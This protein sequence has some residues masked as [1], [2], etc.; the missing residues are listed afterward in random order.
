MSSL[1]EPNLVLVTQIFI[2][3]L[4]RQRSVQ[5]L[6]RQKCAFLSQ[7]THFWR[8]KHNFCR[9]NYNVCRDKHIFVTTN[10]CLLRQNFC[11]DKNAT[12]GSARSMIGY[13]QREERRSQYREPSPYRGRDRPPWGGGFIW[14]SLPLNIHT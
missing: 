1:E 2:P 11:R 14:N 8:D 9:D 7:Q 3:H 5:V 13:G 4:A 12:C 10:T 6:S